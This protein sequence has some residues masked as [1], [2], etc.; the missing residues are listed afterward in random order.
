MSSIM[1]SALLSKNVSELSYVWLLLGSIT[2]ILLFNSSTSVFSGAKNTTILKI[3]SIF[4]SVTYTWVYKFY[5]VSGAITVVFDD[6]FF[7][8]FYPSG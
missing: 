3:G 8:N 1:K 5:Q 4:I 6:E 2:K 7:R